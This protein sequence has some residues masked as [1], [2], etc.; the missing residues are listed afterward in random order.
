MDAADLCVDSITNAASTL[1]YGVMSW[2]QNNQS[3]TAVTAIGTFPAPSYWWE[4]GAVWGGMIDYWAYTNDESYVPTIQQ[5]LLAQVG[6]DNNYMPPAYYAS[7]G[8]DDQAFWAI[9]ALSAMEY[10]FPVPEGNSSSLWFDLAEAVFNTQW[11]R[12]DT[13]SC[14]GG[15][16][17]Q[18]FSYN[19]GYNYKNSISNGAFFQIAARLAHY[20]GN[21]TYVDWAERAWN[22]MR[23]VDLID[24]QYNVF[25]G[26]DD[27]INCSRVDH[28]AWSYNPSM[29]LYGTAMLYNFTN[30]SQIWEERTTGLLQSCARTFFSPYKNATNIAYEF[31]CEE[32]GN[33][34]YDQLSF[35]AY[36]ARWMAKASVV[37]PYISEAVNRLLTPSAQAAAQACSGGEDGTT[38]GQK[39]YVGGYDG[40]T[41]LGQE[42]SALEV[43]QSLLLLRGDVNASHLYPATSRDVHVEVS[44]PQTASS[45]LSIAPG[46][47]ATNGATGGS[48]GTKSTKSAADAGMAITASHGR[49]NALAG[50]ALPVLVGL[51][52]GGGILG[53]R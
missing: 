28:T 26:T 21:Q 5:A 45:T 3:S 7:L 30:G 46:T 17:W 29:L 11:P 8:N 2:Y 43:V 33:C 16:R 32:Q 51:L 6:P 50:M 12:W 53:A 47:S 49:R 25:D 44:N 42:L 41:G 34:N 4:G 48:G 10:G 31:A 19:A 35:K 39:W 27:T 13:T 9:A 38:C 22:W 24:G 23:G 20:T 18:I 14:N 37:A 36:L 52:L 15:L 40:N 1:A